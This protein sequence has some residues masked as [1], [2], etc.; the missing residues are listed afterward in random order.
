MVPLSLK[1]A[2]VVF[3][4]LVKGADNKA[5][6]RQYSLFKPAIDRYEA[7]TD[8]RR[9]LFIAKIF[10]RLKLAQYFDARV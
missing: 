1:R 2:L 5:V 4:E 9:Q 6:P 8:P 7:D 3:Q 10:L